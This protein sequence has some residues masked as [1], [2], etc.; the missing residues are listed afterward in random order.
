MKFSLTHLFKSVIAFWYVKDVQ[1]VRPLIVPS[2]P[3]CTRKLTLYAMHR[4]R[5][6]G[7]VATAIA[8]SG[9]NDLGH[10][11]NPIFLLMGHFLYRLRLAKKRNSI[12]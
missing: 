11:V 7:Q 8:L 10:S 5:A 1:F 4:A 9:F 3:Y 6:I 2:H 12:D